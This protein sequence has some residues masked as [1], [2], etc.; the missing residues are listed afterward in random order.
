MHL[1]E[2]TVDAVVDTWH[3]VFV[4]LRCGCTTASSPFPSRAI[5]E[6]PR[7][8]PWLPASS[9]RAQSFDR[10]SSIIIIIKNK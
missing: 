8:G 2:M 9:A 5:R 10:G 7:Y 3:A 1:A 6:V 4:M